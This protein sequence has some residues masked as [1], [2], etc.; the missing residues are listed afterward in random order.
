VVS[1]SVLSGKE[2]KSEEENISVC[3]KNADKFVGNKIKA[4]E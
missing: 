4:M 2:K 1:I 3:V